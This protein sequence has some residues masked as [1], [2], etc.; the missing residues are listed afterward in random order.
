MSS[1]IEAFIRDAAQKRGIDP[2]YAI[3]VA[4]SEGGLTEYARLG[5]FSG[6][7]WFSG[8]SWWPFQLHYG[9]AGTPYAEWGTSAGMGNA[10]TTLTGWQPGDPRAWKDSVRYA[11][12]RVKRGGWGPWYGAKY[13]GITGF[14]GVDRDAPW[15][16]NAERWDYENGVQPMPKVTYNRQE[17][18][19]P[20]DESWDCSQ[21]S[22]EWALYALGRA[23]AD[24]W[25]E[26]T[27]IAEG[28]V[29]RTQGLLDSSGAGLADFVRRQYGEFGFDSNN[30]PA[31]SWEWAVHEGESQPDG[32][33]H[34]YPV[35]L[36]GRRFGAEGHW[37]GLRDYD[38]SRRVLLLANPA[39]GYDGIQQ[40][41]NESQ[42]TARGPW[43]AVR[44]WHPD[45]FATVPTPPTPSQPLLRERVAAWK[46][47]LLAVID[48]MP[49]E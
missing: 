48:R 22:L 37:V 17:P 26:E 13:I 4:Q 31:I 46:E 9:G 23:P 39:N 16:A 3:R 6:P 30:A 35:L 8:K 40:T 14:D 49:V 11:L 28:V 20:Q 45:L 41:L 19:H 12:N 34:G 2:E 27:M 15:D 5:D 44:I 7:P 36:G 38:P 25:L 18:A 1:E 10:F 21:D 32:S 42:F 29:S 47:E 33:G 43:S 24:G